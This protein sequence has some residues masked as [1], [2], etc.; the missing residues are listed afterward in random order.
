MNRRRFF[1]AATATV[2]AAVL[3]VRALASTAPYTFTRHTCVHDYGHM[4]ALAVST[5]V[6]GVRRRCALPV[7]SSFWNGLSEAGKEG[8]W[9]MIERKV[10]YETN[11]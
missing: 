1:Q 9:K 8:V 3:P 11:S 6:G 7:P 10:L 2:V 4:V 5:V